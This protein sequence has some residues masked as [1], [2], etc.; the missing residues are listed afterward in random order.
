LPGIPEDEVTNFCLWLKEHSAPYVGKVTL[1]KRLKNTPAV[2]FG[3]ISSN[4]RMMMNMMQGEIDNPQ[5]AARQMEEMS[6]NQ[7]LEINP[8]HQVMIKLNQLKNAS[9]KKAEKVQRHFLNSVLSDSQVP[10]DF[11]E[12]SKLNLELL[13]DYLQMK[14]N[15]MN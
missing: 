15:K 2:L 11:A 9:P 4:M 6:R 10:H 1:S 12:S 5:E 7:T 3:Q 8:H 14:V 13:D